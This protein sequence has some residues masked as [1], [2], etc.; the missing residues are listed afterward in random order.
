M[1]CVAGTSYS[2]CIILTRRFDRSAL[3]RYISI[4][5][6]FSTAAADSG[7][8]ASACCFYASASID[9]QIAMFTCRIPCDLNARVVSCTGHYVFASAI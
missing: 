2:C 7:R 3:Y 4:N 8:V 9:C 5:A 6:L 1:G